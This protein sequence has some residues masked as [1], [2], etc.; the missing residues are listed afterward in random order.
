[1]K[2]TV[3]IIIK[4]IVQG[5]GYRPF[6][7]NL[8]ISSGINGYVL[9][10]GNGVVVEA[11][12]PESELCRFINLLKKK[13]PS[14]ALVTGI[15]I[16]KSEMSGYKEFSV[17]ESKVGA[18]RSVLISPDLS[19]CDACLND[20]RSKRDRRAGYPFITCTG[21][22]PRF[23]I[24][25]DTPYDRERTSM[26]EFDM[27]GDCGR[28]YKDPSDRRFHAETNSCSV[29]GPQICLFNHGK[30]NK[31]DGP[32]AEAIKLI[33]EGKIIAVKGLG[34]FHLVCDAAN[35]KAVNELRAAKGRDMKPFAIMCAD[36]RIANKL[37]KLGSAELELLVSPERPIVLLEKR[38]KPR[39]RLSKYVAPNNKYL[40]IMLPYT[41]LHYLLL[42]NDLKVIV[43]TSANLSEE[44][45]CA[46]REE[47]ENKLSKITAY[48]LDHDRKILT[49]IDD[50]VVR[51]IA[52]RPCMI[53]R[54][55]GYVPIPFSLD[56]N[57]RSILA[58]GAELKGAFTIAKDGNA[59]VS[60]HIGDLKSLE[61]YQHFKSTI[62]HFKRVFQIEP[63][64]F[65]GDLHPD[66]LNSRYSNKLQKIQ[67]HHA[68]IASC[69]AENELDGKVIGVA[70]D[71]MGMGDDGTIWGAE[72]LIADRS[73]FKR[74]AHLKYVPLPGGDKASLEP[75]RM[76]I[77][78]LHSVYGKALL[79]LKKLPILKDIDAK[80]IKTI[81]EMIEKDINSPQA[82]SM[83]RFFDAVS[84]ILG[85]CYRNSYEGQAAAELEHLIK[86][87][88]KASYEF[89]VVEKD[90]MTIIDPKKVIQGIVADIRS[91]GV[92][93]K[94]H[95]TVAKMILE[96]CK[97]ARKSHGLNKVCLSGGCFQNKYLTE[98]TLRVLKNAGFKA[99][100]HK[101]LPPNDACISF[102][103]AAVAAR[104]LT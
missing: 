85:I 22:G 89:E 69:M 59:F 75:W 97:R 67:H 55:R 7:Y 88:S 38:S 100:V 21:C 74:Y 3:R 98:E 36:T 16:E 28:E 94:F 41:P 96:V 33:K 56:S 72:F 104:S 87:K 103:Q 25:A 2:K 5:V 19:T 64:V 47:V 54:A 37:C 78:Y 12:G 29:C 43:A 18:K 32:V 73:E 24:V 71:G 49:R 31:T 66:Y 52:G 44:P 79:K 4:G 82:S 68:H 93:S 101:K 17:R 84:A 92:A 53:R 60:Q 91:I 10:S 86:K 90:G 34:G 50:S 65:A 26:S 39:L 1:M 102:G 81:V 80:E 46:S 35:D 58:L 77:S 62:G 76:G 8:A 11:E 9:N 83:G 30:R 42:E 48:V 57:G 95:N 20:F 99:Y 27:C 63:Q 45:I 13:Y 70:L 51:I 15:E 61:S 23:S 6:I 14:K 40:G